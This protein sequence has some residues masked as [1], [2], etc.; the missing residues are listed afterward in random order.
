MLTEAR[1]FYNQGIGGITYWAPN[2]NIV[3][4]PRR[5]RLQETS[6]EDPMVSSSYAVQFV[7]GM[8]EGDARNTAMD[9]STKGSPRRL[10]LSAWCKHFTETGKAWTDFL[11]MPRFHLPIDSNF[12]PSLRYPN[13]GGCGY[14]HV[15]KMWCN[16]NITQFSHICKHSTVRLP[17]FIVARLIS[18]SDPSYLAR[19]HVN[20]YRHTSY[21]YERSTVVKQCRWLW[22]QSK[23][24]LLQLISVYM[25]NKACS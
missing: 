15:G 9:K 18:A 4:D 3:R 10:N 1:A 22:I 2:I 17:N 5:G 20:V 7:R 21:R 16:L 23:K 12:W 14:S 13:L 6:G 25:S 11:S 24:V 19:K 8:Q